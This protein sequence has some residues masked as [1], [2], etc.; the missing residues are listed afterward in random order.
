MSTDKES[1]REQSIRI[2]KKVNAEVE[3][4]FDNF[5]QRS[6]EESK[7]SK[8]V[9]LKLASLKGLINRVDMLKKIKDAICE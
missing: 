4:I 1:L 3:A 9:S 5:M 7:D 2:K 8:E 6:S